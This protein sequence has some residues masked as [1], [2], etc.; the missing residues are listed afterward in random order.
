MLILLSP[1]VVRAGQIN[2][3]STYR[4]YWGSFVKSFKYQFEAHFLLDEKASGYI[5]WTLVDSPRR[6][7]YKLIGLTATE[8]VR[9]SYDQTTRTLKLEGYKKDDPNGIIGLDE[10]YLNVSDDGQRIYGSTSNYGSWLGWFESDPEIILQNMK[11]S[12][13]NVKVRRNFKPGDESPEKQMAMYERACLILENHRNYDQRII[14]DEI[15]AV[16]KF[17]K[18]QLEACKTSQQCQFSPEDQR[19]LEL[20]MERYNTAKNKY[21]Y[22]YM[23]N[24]KIKRTQ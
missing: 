4:G 22:L 7:E 16:K 17:K 12:T 15:E 20:L 10:Y 9:G 2:E 1:T 11:I 3:Y 24:E 14:M 6:Y 21:I 18:S 23:N 13:I 19:E 8:Y 5:V